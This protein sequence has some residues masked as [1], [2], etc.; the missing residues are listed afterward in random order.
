MTI[1][2]STIIITGIPKATNIIININYI[3]IAVT[4][5]VSNDIFLS[6]GL[7]VNSPFPVGNPLPIILYNNSFI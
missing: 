5:L 2:L 1:V 6:F 4:N 3:I 7:N